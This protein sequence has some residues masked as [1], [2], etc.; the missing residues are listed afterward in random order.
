MEKKTYWIACPKCSGKMLMVR[1]DTKLIN[2]PGYC[3]HCKKKSVIS[4]EPLSR[5]VKYI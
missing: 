4:I 3:K 5:V 2:F 1:E